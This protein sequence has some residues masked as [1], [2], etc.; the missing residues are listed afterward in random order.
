MEERK[1][2]LEEERLLRERRERELL[3]SRNLQWRGGGFTDIPASIRRT[4][5]DRAEPPLDAKIGDVL[6]T[7]QEKE[8]RAKNRDKGRRQGGR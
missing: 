4:G 6:G 3:R 2:K 1:A 8:G 7:P 5:F